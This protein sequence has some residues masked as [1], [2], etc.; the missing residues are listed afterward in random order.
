MNVCFEEVVVGACRWFFFLKEVGG[1]CCFAVNKEGEGGRGVPGFV[2]F[3]FLGLGLE[4][5]GVGI[6]MYVAREKKRNKRGVC[7]KGEGSSRL[8]CSEGKN[9]G[10][11]L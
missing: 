5:R 6:Y 3:C 8:L 2:C 10:G 9:G 1:K 7:V 4:L 11:V